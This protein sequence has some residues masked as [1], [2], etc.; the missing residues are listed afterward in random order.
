MVALNGK[1]TIQ[2]RLLDL[3]SRGHDFLNQFRDNPI[4]GGIF[5]SEVMVT[6]TIYKTSMVHWK[7][8]SSIQIEYSQNDNR[9]LNNLMTIYNII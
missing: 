3:F 4:V 5:Q 9:L 8:L 2:K 7:S 1:S 6:L